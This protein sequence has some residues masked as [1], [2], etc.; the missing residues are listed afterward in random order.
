MK[1]TD[2]N[3][4]IDRIKTL[5]G[6]T[7]DERAALLGLLNETKTYGLVWEDK[8]E[9]VEERLR[10]ELPVLK[11]VRSRAIISDNADSPNHILI[12][13][14][15]LEALTTLAYTHEGKIDV[16]YIDPPY[17]TGKKDF[18]YNDTFIDSEDSFRHSKWLS[19]ISRRL[20]I[21]KKLLSDKGVIFLS[22][23]DNEQASLKLLCDELFGES[24]FLG[25]LILK[26][27]TDNNP[28]QI[29]TEHEYMLCYCKRR[30]TQNNWQRQ[31][32]AAK[33][34]IAAG[35][36]ILSSGVAIDTAQK[37]LRKWIRANKELLPQVTHYNNI[38]KKGVYSSSGNSS[39][40][41]PGGYT[42]DIIHPITG[43]PCPKPAN[44]WRW[45]QTTFLAYDN[46]GEI[47]WGKDHSTQ[48]HVKKRI[49]TSMEYLR[50]LIYEDNRGTTK[51]LAEI[52]GGEKRF[53]NPKPH[54]VL[55][56]VIDFASDKDSII[57]DFFAGSGTTLHAVMQLNADDGGKRQCILC[58]NN[59]NG[60]CENVTYER[61]K[62]VI[63]GYTKPNGEEVEGLHANNLRYYRTDFVG[64]RRTP[65][66]MRR[67][68]LLASDML[69][70]KESLYTEHDE[71]GGME[72]LKNGFRYFTS[73]NPGGTRRNIKQAQVSSSFARD[74]SDGKK[75]MLI[76]YNEEAIYDIVDA[77]EA[78]EVASPIIVY[79]FSPG[80]DAWN[81]EFESVCDK[82]RLTA[83]PAAI[84][85]AY[86]RVLPKPKT[87][88]LNLEEVPKEEKKETEDLFDFDEE[89][90]E[91]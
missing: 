66:N 90:G 71:F 55:S 91:A 35:K 59:E 52:F 54:T 89:G 22:I 17:N 56:R 40:P 69:C 72:T 39:N 58:T 79:V 14:D 76:V 73:C 29:N 74:F 67:L 10:M 68:M 61:N 30:E 25:Q 24:N 50:T 41:H 48:P 62:R 2:R 13:G 45:P 63:Q 7:D 84:Y 57:L 27:A 46:A 3:K 37:E 34:L 21:A 18:V 49:E 53:D 47:E 33:R 42:Y 86:K 44:G 43:L 1:A 83:L 31:S 64:R 20:K 81:S 82:V 70:I 6:L 32:Q 15:N 87:T 4:L 28:S 16:I 60:I 75:Q 77:L 26:T 19:F 78:M 12:E 85:N 11:E 5:E 23:D 8:P 51:T 9:E 38:D 65:Q 88:L 36:E 80:N